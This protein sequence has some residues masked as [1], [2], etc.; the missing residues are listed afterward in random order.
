MNRKP[1][2]ALLCAI[3]VCFTAAINAGEL[4]EHSS[5]K[6][7]MHFRGSGDHT[8]EVRAIEGN[9]TVEAYDG[10]DVEMT[11]EKSLSARNEQEM[12]AARRDVVL[13]TADN[14]TTIGAIVRYPNQQTCGGA[15]GYESHAGYH[16]RFDFR[17]RV[18]RNVRL[19]LCT[20]NDSVVAVS[21]T[22]GD[23]DIKNVNGRI[24]MTGI[25]GSGNALT[26]NGAV[27][28][29]FISTPPHPSTFR[30]T[31]GDVVITLPEGSSPQLHMRTLNGKVTASP[32]LR[33]AQ[34]GVELTLETLNGDVR[35]L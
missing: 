24:A 18:P 17:I 31:N 34:D 6:L 2:F 19:K 5:Q 30:T 26:V 11:V 13:D 1:L 22:A 35:V 21:G 14:A 12:L 32:S 9:I 8:L 33:A 15:N 27:A 4:T 3:P 16:V 28:A 29:S 25:A 20:I 10:P 7:T 23:F